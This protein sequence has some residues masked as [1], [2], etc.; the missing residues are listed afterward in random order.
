[1]AARHDRPAVAD[2]AVGRLRAWRRF[3]VLD[4][5][6]LA[7]SSALYAAL[8]TQCRP[9]RY[10][11]LPAEPTVLPYV[12]LTSDVGHRLLSRNTRKQ[13]RRALRAAEADGG[14]FE[15]HTD[16]EGVTRL[17]PELMDLHDARFGPSSQIYR[18]PERRGFHLG[19]AGALAAAGQ[20]R[21][22]RLSQCD[23][24]TALLYSLAW[25]GRLLAYGGGIRPGA[26]TPGH[27]LTAL[28]IMSAE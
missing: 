21:L 28:A 7:D 14:G 22:Y 18:G 10:A 4:L 17:L 24:S 11:A 5:D 19:A 27:V 12:A 3:D 9:P 15:V 20:V 6:G 26:G 2:A 23:R 1:V 8:T 25:D 16:P 13:M